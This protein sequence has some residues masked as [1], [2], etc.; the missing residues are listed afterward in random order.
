MQFTQPDGQNY[1]YSS[2]TKDRARREEKILVGWMVGWFG[3]ASGRW[4]FGCYTQ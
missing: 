4:F 3:T 2:T 1:T